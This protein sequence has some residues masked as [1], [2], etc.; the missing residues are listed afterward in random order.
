MRKLRRYKSIKTSFRPNLRPFFALSTSS[1]I[2]S[3][4]DLGKL[5]WNESKSFWNKAQPKNAPNPR[6]GN[7]FIALIYH[8][9]M[10]YYSIA[11]VCNLCCTQNNQLIYIHMY[12]VCNICMYICYTYNNQLLY[13]HM[14]CVCNICK[15]HTSNCVVRIHSVVFGNLQA[16]LN[17]RHPKLGDFSPIGR[18]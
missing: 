13:T 9:H 11:C 18:F 12:C 10:P 8:S 2:S 1:R 5:N 4:C 6:S 16:S 7:D 15:L 14:Y 3:A 17:R